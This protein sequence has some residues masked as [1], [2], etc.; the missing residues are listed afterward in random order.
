MKTIRNVMPGSSAR[1]HEPRQPSGTGDQGDRITIMV[2]DL[3]SSMHSLSFLPESIQ[4]YVIF[5]CY[6]C[7]FAVFLHHYF[8]LWNLI[9]FPYVFFP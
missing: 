4:N 9:T 7:S 3:L 1:G 5:Q 8:L 2:V 6:Y